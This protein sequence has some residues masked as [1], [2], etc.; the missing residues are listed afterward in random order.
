MKKVEM[1]ISSFFFGKWK[2]IKT[3]TETIAVHVMMNGKG[4]IVN[5]ENV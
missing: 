1:N 3:K 2:S 5:D 4:G